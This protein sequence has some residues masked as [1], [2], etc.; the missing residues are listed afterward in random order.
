M[1]YF[2]VFLPMKDEEKSK[3]HRPEH[4]R[5]LEKKQQE[6]HIFAKGPFTD[7]AGGLVIYKAQNRNA[8]EVIVKEDP[9]IQT[10]ARGYEIHE[11]DMKQA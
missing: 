11:W 7:G 8:V 5:F 9:Y 3:I 2:A 10:G 6:G 1:K 4:L